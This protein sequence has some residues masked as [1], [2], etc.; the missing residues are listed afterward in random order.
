MCKACRLHRRVSADGQRASGR[1]G[2]LHET[3]LTDVCLVKKADRVQRAQR[4]AVVTKEKEREFSYY[5]PHVQVLHVKLTMPCRGDRAVQVWDRAAG[6]PGVLFV[7]QSRPTVSPGVTYA[8]VSSCGHDSG[9]IEQH[10]AQELAG[11][12]ATHAGPAE[13]PP[14][15]HPPHAQTLAPVQQ[16]HGRRLQLTP[17][18]CTDPTP[19]S[20]AGHPYGRIHTGGAAPSALPRSL[21]CDAQT[22]VHFSPPQNGMSTG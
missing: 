4:G 17:R 1:P 7:S 6:Y 8:V 13:R 10:V 21:G 3:S 14:R 20:D 19:P 12:W 5:C 18:G 16:H 2:H 11:H 9:H 15:R 22:A